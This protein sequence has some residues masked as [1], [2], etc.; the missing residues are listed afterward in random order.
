MEQSKV[1]VH[2]QIGFSVCVC[3][4]C[5]ASL[6]PAPLGCQAP[7]SA[8]A[9]LKSACSLSDGVEQGTHRRLLS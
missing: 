4:V 6:P 1:Q 2:G 3:S 7:V 5:K 9:A 8:S